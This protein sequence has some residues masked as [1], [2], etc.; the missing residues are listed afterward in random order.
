VAEANTGDWCSTGVTPTAVFTGTARQR[1]QRAAAIAAE[2]GVSSDGAWAAFARAD[3]NKSGSL[4]KRELRG[5]LGL[6]NIQLNRPEL[7]AQLVS[8]DADADGTL[9][10]DEFVRLA[11][12]LVASHTHIRDVFEKHDRDGSG[13]LSTRELRSALRTLGVQLTGE[14]AR[15]TLAHYDAD[16]SGALS[17]AE[18]AGLVRSLAAAAE[19]EEKK[20]NGGAAAGQAGAQR[21]WRRAE[22]ALIERE[23]LAGDAPSR[24]VEIALQ[25]PELCLADMAAR[26]LKRWMRANLMTLTSFFLDADRDGSGDIDRTELR[27]AL[28]ALQF[29]CTEREVSDGGAGAAGSAVPYFLSPFGSGTTLTV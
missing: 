12:S 21:L 4:S 11:L 18:F 3:K 22:E 15:R 20:E 25:L 7:S 16:E 23:R 13:E 29:R 8:H 9:T 24:G 5:A 14:Q 10:G 2:A 26:A 1:A 27:L 28:Q 17:I 19:A 6:L